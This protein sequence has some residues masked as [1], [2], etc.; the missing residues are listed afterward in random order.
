MSTSNVKIIQTVPFLAVTN[1][2]KSIAF[3]VDGLGFEFQ[4]KWVDNGKLQ[5]ASRISHRRP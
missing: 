3:Y 2:T 5:H 1:M 4:N